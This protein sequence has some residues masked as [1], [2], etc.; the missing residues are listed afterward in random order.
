MVRMYRFQVFMQY[1]IV[2]NWSQPRKF[3][4]EGSKPTALYFSEHCGAGKMKR[5][6]ERHTPNSGLYGDS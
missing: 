4:P 3:K 6:T 2:S 5:G 1:V